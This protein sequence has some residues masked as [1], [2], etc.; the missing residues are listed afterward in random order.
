M[1]LDRIEI[2]N[3]RSIFP[4]DSNRPF[5]LDLGNA[6]NTIVG[7]NN[8]GKSNVFRALAVALDPDYTFDRSKDMPS[9]TQ[10]AK[11]VVTLTFSVPERGRASIERTLIKYL[12]EYERLAYPEVRQTFA[13]RG[14]VKLRV[15][16]E[17]GDDSLGTRR[18]VFVA[19]GAGA[20]SLEDDDLHGIKTLRQF[21]K[22]LHFVMIRSG[23]DLESL[24]EGKFRDILR[25]VLRDNESEN[26]LLAEQRRD[27][28]VDELRS[29]LLQ[30]LTDRITSELNEVFPEISGAEL[31]PDVPTLEGT[32]TGM[33]VSV[34]DAAVTD[35]AEKG[36]GVR[37]GLIVAILRHL[38]D[39]GKR[40]MLFAVE[41]PEAFLHPAAQEALRED[42]E[43]LAD[44][45]DVS[46]LVASHSPYIVSRADGAK[47]FALDKNPLGRTLLVD[48]A[49]GADPQAAVI[50]GLFRG[51]MVA[52][53]LDRAERIGSD[54]RGVIVVEGSTDVAYMQLAA[55]RAGRHDLVAD[56]ALVPAGAGVLGHHPGGACLAAMQAIVTRTSTEL[57]VAAVFDNDSPG[58]EAESLLSQIG[59]KT[60]DWKKGETLLNYHHAFEPSL[61][62]FAF[63]AEDLWSQRIMKEFVRSAGED[64][65][66][67]TKTSRPHQ[68]GGY[69][70]DF[71]GHAKGA[72]V[73]YLE[74]NVKAKDCE[75][76]VEFLELI[77]VKLGIDS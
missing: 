35:L 12:D 75:L 53:L 55:A 36:T 71:H 39:T 18:E 14:I 28:Y 64:A 32:L 20:R 3:F 38:A 54:S 56:L 58:Q 9:T 6:M 37:G 43:R 67:K 1:R 65:V 41:E 8:C 16:I 47:V 40:S 7:P 2:K 29:G 24:M 22:C 57:P 68:V 11:P 34:T 31:D 5:S 74:A 13:S 42:L 10:W 30:P 15:T 50:G 25:T 77:R 19:S 66:L 51:R 69:Q 26:Y 61:K 73:E 70:Y 76:W 59:K 60:G 45:H 72:F 17:G 62:W 27:R 52:D 46:L 44:R 21:H 49:E 33:R 63:E 23:Q 48:S 4:D